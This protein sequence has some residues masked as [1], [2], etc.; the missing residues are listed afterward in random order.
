MSKDD[1]DWLENISEDDE[2]DD[3]DEG[4]VKD[5]DEDEHEEVGEDGEEEEGMAEEI[6]EECKDDRD[7]HTLRQVD[8]VIKNTKKKPKSYHSLNNL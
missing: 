8:E 1:Y 3:E 6:V 5:K 4:K 7:E 2:E